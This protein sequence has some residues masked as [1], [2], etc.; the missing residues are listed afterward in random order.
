MAIVFIQK[1]TNDCY[2][3]RWNETMIGRR[4]A[5]SLR[6]ETEAV[7]KEIAC[8]G[9]VPYFASDLSWLWPS[10]RSGRADVIWDETRGSWKEFLQAGK[11]L[12][13][14]VVYIDVYEFHWEELE[15]DIKDEAE[16]HELEPAEINEILREAE[17]LK[18]YEG[19]IEVFT[20]A[21]LID[22][23]WHAYRKGAG[24][25]SL[26]DSILDRL[27]L[28]QEEGEEPELSEDELEKYTRQLARD[29]HFQ[30]AKTKHVRYQIARRLFKEEEEVWPYLDE[31]T[32][33]AYAIIE[34][35]LRPEQEQA[36]A[37]KA[38]KLLDNGL[39]QRAVAQWMN[40]SQGKLSRIL[41]EFPRQETP[42]D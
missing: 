11:A 32:E 40:L 39:S 10:E 31:I 15:N 27:E 26:H 14:R 7:I 22:G 42:A 38:Y 20:L 19:M 13:G 5:D 16:E 1:E 12:E 17:I 23:T 36:L 35:E 41:S 34:T 18:E 9:L 33:S 29:V 24:W 30:R 8:L 25:E 4:Q 2:Q 3:N 28:E 21:Y 6:E 37:D